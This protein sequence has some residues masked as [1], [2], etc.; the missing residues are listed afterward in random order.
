MHPTPETARFPYVPVKNAL[1][2]VA[3]RPIL[4]FHLSYQGRSSLVSGLVDSG[5]DVNVLP[6]RVGLDLGLNWQEQGRAIELSGNLAHY[7]A[8][9]VILLA[10]V[11]AFRPVALAFAWTQAEQVPLLLGQV[12]FLREFDICFFGFQREFSITLRS[13]L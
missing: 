8:R 6:Y 11:E 1:G 12:N 9:G 10:Q 5:A 4:S 7:K 13:S 3:W 2:E